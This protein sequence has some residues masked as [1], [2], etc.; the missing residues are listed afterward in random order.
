MSDEKISIETLIASLQERAKELN[1]IYRIEEYMNEP[2][3]T[4]ESV[5]EGIIEAIPP[6]LQYPDICQTKIVLDGKIYSTPDLK[7]T[8]W[9]QFNDVVVQDKNI[10]RISVYYIEEM[11]TADHGPFLKEEV[12]LIET[13]AYQ[14]RVA[15]YPGTIKEN[16]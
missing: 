12:K 14:K 1:C 7:E 9:V 5:C 6:G 3:A 4:I 11:P 16:R 10:G 2:D 8:E 15:G 13:M